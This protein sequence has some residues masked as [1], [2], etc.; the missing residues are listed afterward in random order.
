MIFEHSPEHVVSLLDNKVGAERH[1]QGANWGLSHDL[2]HTPAM[3]GS[4]I[5]K[6]IAQAK[7]SL[8]VADLIRQVVQINALARAWGESLIFSD[9][10]TNKELDKY[11]SELS[12]I[13]E[14]PER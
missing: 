13:L 4:L 14:M 10:A 6:Q 1:R 5:E 9:N 2:E 3:W 12:Q 11:T 8:S 7:E